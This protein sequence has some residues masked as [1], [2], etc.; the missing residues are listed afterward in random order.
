[1]STKLYW[2]DDVP[3]PAWPLKEEPENTSITSKF[4]DGSM[5]SRS[6]FTRSRRKWTLQWNHISRRSY[7]RIMDF[8]VHKAKFAAN[9][10]IWTNTDS[11]DLSYD[12]MNPDEEQVEVRITNV[13]EWTNDDLNYWNGSI[14]LTEV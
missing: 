11:I 13:G 9:S 1:M 5:Q 3:S 14:E 4:E 12:Y 7:L 6:K 2:P 10:F 8:V